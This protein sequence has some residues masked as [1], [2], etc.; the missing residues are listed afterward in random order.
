MAEGAHDIVRAHVAA[1]LG[2]VERILADGIAAGEFSA[3]LKPKAA[4]RAFLQATAQF[5]HPALVMQPPAPTAGEAR[6]VFR[7]LLAGLRG[8][9]A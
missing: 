2:Q 6:A 8:R 9:S 4:A 1:L 3:D 5:H 7:L